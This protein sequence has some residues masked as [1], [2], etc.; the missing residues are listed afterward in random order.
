M[1]ALLFLW[2]S[3]A[4]EGDLRDRMGT[5]N[6]EIPFGYTISQ[7]VTVD[8]ITVDHIVLKS[9]VIQDEL[10]NK[11]KKYTVMFSQY[12]LSQILED[13]TLLDQSKEKTFDFTTVNTEITMEL[14]ATEDGINTNNVYYVSIIPK[15]NNGILG[16]ISNELRFKLATQKYGE[17]KP[18]DTW[19]LTHAAPWANMSLAHITHTITS[20]RATLRRTS[21]DGSDKIDI[22][23]WNPTS[24][25]FE[26]L[27]SVNMSDETYTF[28]LTRNGE[29]LVNFMPNNGGTEYRYSFIANG[30]TPGTTTPTS[31]TRPIIGNNIPATWPKENVLIALAI[32][33]VFYIVYRKVRAKH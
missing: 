33:V 29:Y 6:D 19:A 21:I 32:A 7:K 14:K 2:F 4:V 24:E 5:L 27:G 31:S 9:P 16:E 18:T 10:G 12:P 28:T 20:N 3:F 25:M 23:L 22:F 8:S 13:T 1:F 30:V 17:G 26:R 15:D 11:I